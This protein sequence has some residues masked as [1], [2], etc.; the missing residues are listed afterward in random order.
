MLIVSA[1]LMQD[2]LVSQSWQRCRAGLQDIHCQY[3]IALDVLSEVHSHFEP[4]L[5]NYSVRRM[6]VN[7]DQ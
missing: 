2:L 5:V 7:K 3:R 6:K 4:C 1:R